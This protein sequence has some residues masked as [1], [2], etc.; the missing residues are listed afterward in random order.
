MKGRW[1][2]LLVILAI[3][4]LITFV[5]PLHRSVFNDGGT[6]MYE[7]FFYTVVSWNCFVEGEDNKTT[8]YYTATRVYW[9]PE[10]Q[11][12]INVLWDK[13]EAR[14]DFDEHLRV[15]EVVD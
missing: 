9:Y 14:E 8:Y 2:L 13:E 10:N 5:F 3:G 1:K 11:Q 4:V 7:A 15:F 6:K 12:D